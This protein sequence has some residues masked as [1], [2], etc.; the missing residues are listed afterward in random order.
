MSRSLAHRK[1]WVG[2]AL[3]ASGIIALIGLASWAGPSGTGDVAPSATGAPSVVAPSGATPIRIGAVFPTP[4]TPPALA[5]PGAGR[6]P[7][8]GGPGERR[9][10]HRR[11]TDRARRA[12]PR[13]RATMRRRSWRRFA[14][15]GVQVVIG[16]YS[17]DLSIAASAAADR[18]GL[19]YWEAGA[20]ADRL[21][22]RGLPIVFRVG[23]SGSEPRRELGRVRGDRAGARAS[24]GRRRHAAGRD[25]RR[26]RRLCAARSPTPPSRPRPRPGMPVVAADRLQPDHSR[27]GRG[28]WPSSRRPAR[29]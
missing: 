6:R 7:D 19:V 1:S 25:R 15:E 2:V 5:G 26:R 21:T 14:A 18:A 8:R 24:A 20:V 12:R 13:A 28:S 16:A 17:S 9:R 22:G 11:P 29:T 3:V 4:A 23:A 10:R 27:T